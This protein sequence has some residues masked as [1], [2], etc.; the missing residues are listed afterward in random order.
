MTEVRLS[1]R[2]AAIALAIIVPAPSI[3]ALLAFWVA[4]GPVG[5]AAYALGKLVLYATPALWARFV[6]GERWAVRGASRGNWLLG[7]AIGLAIT[8]AIVAGWWLLGERALDAAAMRQTL[9]ANGL[10]TPGRFLLAAAWLTVVNSL[11]EEY[12]FRWFITTRWEAITPRGA[13]WLSALSF[14]AHHL[15]VLS[16]AMVLPVALLTTGGVLVGG[17]IWTWLY[18]R[19]RSVLPGWVSHA[20]VDAA[21]MA[22]GWQMVWGNG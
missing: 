22:V 10:G 4:P 5:S 19:S 21:I 8:A 14:A 7:I 17:L 18:R 9:E 1:R 20:L 11:L 13:T 6:D 3:G 12:V 16:A 2:S 15:V